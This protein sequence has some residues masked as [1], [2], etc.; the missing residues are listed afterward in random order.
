MPKPF[1]NLTGNGCHAHISVWDGNKNKFL[2]KS[3]NL[4]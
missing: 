1:E 3:N 4:A 2:D